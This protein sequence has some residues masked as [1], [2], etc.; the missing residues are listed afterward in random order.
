MCQACHNGAV[1]SPL[2][3]QGLCAIKDVMISRL[4]AA[5]FVLMLKAFA[6]FPYGWSARFGATLGSLLYCI[7]SRR[8]D[9]VHINLSLCFPELDEVGRRNLA[10]TH[11]QHVMRGYIE[12]GVQWF[13]DGR[14]LHDLTELESQIDLASCAE[15]PTIFLGFHFVAIEAGCMFYSTEH[16][17]TSLYTRMK[18]RALEAIAK[19]QRERFHA[20]M[21]PRNNSAKQVIQ[22]LRGGVP[23]MLAADMDFG[24]KDSVFVPFFGTPACTLTSVS[25]LAKLTGARVV[26]FTTE[27]LPDYR[28][29]KLRVFSPLPSFPSDCTETDARMM[30]AFL[31]MQIQRMPEQYYWVHRRFKNRPEGEPAIY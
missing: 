14:K 29:Y 10:R 26:P 6:A 18:N 31:E 28:G 27:V 13:G 3:H 19:T 17:V 11:F 25:R 24:L 9:I 4:N 8:R 23:V 16:P 15:T 30:N 1:D 7:P 5:L 2:C 12:R 20:V 21:V 22:S